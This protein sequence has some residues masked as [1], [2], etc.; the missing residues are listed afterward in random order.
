MFHAEL[1]EMMVM[2]FFGKF[3]FICMISNLAFLYH[4]SEGILKMAG[5][6]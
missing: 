2:G 3:G 1:E 5:R 6:A 4:V